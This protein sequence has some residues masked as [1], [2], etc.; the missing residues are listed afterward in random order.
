MKGLMG[1]ENLKIHCI[2]GINPEE[3]NKPQ[4]IYI[5]LKVQYDLTRCFKSQSIK[6]TVDYARLADIVRLEAQNRHGLLEIFAR[7]VLDSIFEEFDVNWA[8]IRI[9]KP[10]AI[11][12]AQWA[13]VE[14]EQGVRQ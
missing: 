6:D 10:Q 5:D 4:D 9:K 8:W 13:F 14:L 7:R 12:E 3:K 1:F 11:P 2:I